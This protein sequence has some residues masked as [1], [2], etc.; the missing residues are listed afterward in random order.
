MRRA[1]GHK[2]LAAKT[3]QEASEALWSTFKECAHP[4]AA[5]L[6]R[7]LEGLL[8]LDPA[9]TPWSKVFDLF[10]THGHPDLVAIYRRMAAEVPDTAAGSK[11]FLYWSAMR[12]FEREQPAM[13]VEIA[14]D[15]AKLDA[16]YAYEADVL[17]EIEDHLLAAHRDSETLQLAEHFLPVLR[18]DIKRVMVAAAAQKETAELIFQLR[19]GQALRTPSGTPGQ[20]AQA[21]R[22][23]I[24]EVIDA[25][26][27][28]RATVLS[29]GSVPL[30]AWTRADFK[31]IDVESAASTQASQERLRQHESLIGL[32]R[33]MWHH[34]Q[35][36]PG[37]TYRGLYLLLRAVQRFRD[38]G[39]A[40][41]TDLLDCLCT[42]SLEERIACGCPGIMGTNG[43]R[44]ALLL[45]MHEVLLRFAKR[46]RLISGRQ[47][48]LEREF[49]RLRTDLGLA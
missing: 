16:E 3:S 48:A 6:E 1:G 36:P 26:L 44:A 37:S 43:A 41:D 18:K 38:E 10:C 33:E 12:R 25:D 9:L 28:Q 49:G 14:A 8:A 34:E 42:D 39:G 20:L 17:Q 47:D 32:A 31:L 29:A 11:S 22:L 23:D 46:H 13:M 4:G 35:L 40:D 19:V 30:T 21:L 15:F 45:E 27:A 5:Q 24:E 2:E 7:L